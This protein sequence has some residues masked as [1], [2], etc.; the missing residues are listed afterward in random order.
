MPSLRLLFSATWA[1]VI[2]SLTLYLR[3]CAASEKQPLE[4]GGLLSQLKLQV[5]EKI[6]YTTELLNPPSIQPLSEQQEQ[7][8]RHSEEKAR[9]LKRLNK[10]NGNYNSK[11]PRHRL[12]TALHGFY[13]YRQRSLDELNRIKDLYGHAP[14]AHKK[15]V[16]SVVGYENNIQTTQKLI[17]KNDKV[18]Q[19]IVDHA[20]DFYGIEFTELAKFAKEVEAGGKSAERVSVSQAL[21]H[22]ARDWAEDGEHERVATFPQILETLQDKFPN[23]TDENPVRILVPGAGVG[24]LAHDI[25]ELGGFEVTANE[26]SS[27]MNLAYRYLTSNSSTT[28][29]STTIHPFIDWWSHQP[30]TSELHREISFPDVPIDP[31][32]VN[33]VEGDFTTAFQRPEDTNSF[34]II[35]TLFFIDTARNL[36][37]YLETIHRLLKT[38]PKSDPSGK[39]GLW[40][41]VGPLLYGSAPYLQLTL[42]EIIRLSE[43]L[44][45]EFLETDPKWGDLTLPDRKVRGKE[46]P[47]GFNSKALSKNA[48]WAQFWAATKK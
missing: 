44:G 47:Y 40:L 26:W 5:V 43:A 34:D 1:L 22:F 3:Q 19:A 20:L 31:L 9:L 45:F 32:S 6:I 25:A 15:L 39:S 33:L 30:S 46:A 13:R 41:N 12:L 2:V 24:R 10:T 36:V 37:S 8:T 35:V 27:Y 11:H 38:A 48:Y 29:L 42:D 17:D 18:A 16:E 21:K 7:S 28:Q 23:R 14:K 4:E